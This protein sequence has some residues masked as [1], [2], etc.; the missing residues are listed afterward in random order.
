MVLDG[1]MKLAHTD[2]SVDL[3]W[4]QHSSLPFTKQQKQ[5]PGSSITEHVLCMS[6]DQQF[7]DMEC[8]KTHIKVQTPQ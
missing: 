5:T 4:T 8:T 7:K 1:H 2:A 6:T 3:G